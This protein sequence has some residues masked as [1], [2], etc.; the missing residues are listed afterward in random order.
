MRSV[1]SPSKLRC[2][3]IITLGLI[4]A[5][6]AGCTNG[7]KT[8]DSGKSIDTSAREEAGESEASAV[9]EGGATEIG[10]PA[11]VTNAEEEL[12]EKG[13]E[14]EFVATMDKP[15]QDPAPPAVGYEEAPAGMVSIVSSLQGVGEPVKLNDNATVIG[16]DKIEVQ[17]TVVNNTDE[18]VSYVF[19]TSQKLDI[20]AADDEGN[21][22]YRWSKGLRFA[23]VLNTLDLGPGKHFAHEVTLNLEG[24]DRVLPIGTWDFKIMLT[25]TPALEM[26]ARDVT[27]KKS[28]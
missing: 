11:N 26:S 3:A 20:I 27:I 28:E 23:N 9:K 19:A 4:I 24:E 2:P 21:E 12:D 17:V 5:F 16:K 6:F 25:G 13:E 15:T 18:S 7:G 8:D 14:E 22:V 1:F 10:E